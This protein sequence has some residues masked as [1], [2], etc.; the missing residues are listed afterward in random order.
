MATLQNLFQFKEQV[1]IHYLTL[2]AILEYCLIS[3]LYI[4][5]GYQMRKL[6]LKD[7]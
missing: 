1:H 3:S 5:S 7:I 6:R 2:I 4:T